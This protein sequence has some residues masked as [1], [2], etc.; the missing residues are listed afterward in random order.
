[1]GEG[2]EILRVI[3]ARSEGERPIA[4]EEAIVQKA[5]IR[6]PFQELSVEVRAEIEETASA[7]RRM[8]EQ[9]RGGKIS[10]N[11]AREAL[12]KLYEASD[13]ILKRLHI[14][15]G[16]AE[17]FGVENVRENSADTNRFI[18][19]TMLRNAVREEDAQ[20][21][22]ALFGVLGAR[23][24]E[25]KLIELHE[26]GAISGWKQDDLVR[27][28]KE[29][30]A[31]RLAAENLFDRL[32]DADPETNEELET[33]IAMQDILTHVV[34]GNFPEPEAPSD[35]AERFMYMGRL[36]HGDPE[37][38]AADISRLP[39]KKRASGLGRKDRP[40]VRGEFRYRRDLKEGWAPRRQKLGEAEE[41]YRETG[42]YPL[43]VVVV[44]KT[45]DASGN[46]ARVSASP[47][48]ARRYCVELHRVQRSLQS[49]RNR[50]SRERLAAT[51]GQKEDLIAR[52][53]REIF[54]RMSAEDRTA[55]HS[56]EDISIHVV[57]FADENRLGELLR[58]S[59]GTTD[60]DAMDATGELRKRI[61]E[62]M[63]GHDTDEEKL[64]EV[65]SIIDA[66]K[67][68]R[69]I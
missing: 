29:M 26:R 34:H 39:D 11:D 61:E 4:G 10:R 35:L 2:Q 66:W 36:Y 5:E 62:A 55:F 17:L 42:E 46:I 50:M 18:L 67:E 44:A 54:A 8:L 37:R 15:E 12:Q 6:Q 28:Q 65:R 38:L 58:E 68:H 20:N 59:L 32:D 30:I 57:T 40:Y 63:S 64:R 3:P 51:E 43:Q 9:S 48:M 19:D 1:M 7:V 53:K 21:Q 22:D 25:E 33:V 41:K 13:H 14:F 45:P 27:L 60:L 23:L 56:P 24:D 31:A 47:E 16:L 52:T 49:N 69:L